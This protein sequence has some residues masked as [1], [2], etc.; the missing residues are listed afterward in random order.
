MAKTFKLDIVTPERVVF[1][2]DV[3]S[4]VA[5]AEEGYYGVLAG[6]A[7]F[8]STLRAGEVTIR[9]E[10]G[11]VHYATGG[12]FMEVTPKRVTILSESA[13]E[14]AGI[15][16]KRAEEA[17]QRAKERLGAAAKGVD[18][19]RAQLARERAE[20]RLRLARKYAR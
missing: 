5:P 18:R 14:A 17:L 10:R 12:G 9:R 15:D 6:H 11:E 13:E 19:E 3:V 2:E 8:L 4:I 20:N 7:P 1:S 16:V